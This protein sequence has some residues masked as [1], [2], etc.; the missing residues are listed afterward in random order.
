MVVEKSIPDNSNYL[1]FYTTA[2]DH[3]KNEDYHKT[4]VY[5]ELALADKRYRDVMLIKCHDRC[6]DNNVNDSKQLFFLSLV[7][8]E[9][10]TS[11]CMRKLFDKPLMLPLW[12]IKDFKS[13]KPFSFLQYSYYKTGDLV[14]AFEAA[15][16][17]LKYNPESDMMQGNVRFYGSK[18][19]DKNLMLKHEHPTSVDLFKSAT[20]SYSSENYNESHRLF[21]DSLSLYQKEV[22]HCK[23]L[24]ATGHDQYVNSKAPD[25]ND[26][27]SFQDQ[28]VKLY[29]KVME[30]R[31]K[32]AGK[33]DK[34]V[35]YIK[36]DYLPQLLNYLQFSAY[37][38]KDIKFAGQIAATY[39]LINPEDQTMN[40]NYN[41]YL[42]SLGKE[43][44]KHPVLPD[45]I[46]ENLLDMKVLSAIVG[47]R[48]IRKR[49][50][51]KQNYVLGDVGLFSEL[52]PNKD[53][54][55]H[56]TY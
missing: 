55:W 20:K 35:D 24:C 50:K 9:K 16:I 25:L 14:S 39:L 37:Q 49:L 7:T 43:P 13:R 54:L 34:E 6:Q 36:E 42:K 2:V 19:E 5:L 12:V 46:K 26:T 11:K 47:K 21:S 52:K 53:V 4:K 33:H 32:C 56:N 44:E 28:F 45:L 48:E 38:A 40:T 31:Y 10:C 22:K 30:C 3:Y 15:L 27:T 18:V 8:E 17:H 29:H 51:D 1:D 23:I 41:F